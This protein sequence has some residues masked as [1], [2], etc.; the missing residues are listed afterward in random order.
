[1]PPGKQTQETSQ[2]NRS[3]QQLLERTILGDASQGEQDVQSVFMQALLGA[4]EGGAG[5]GNLGRGIQSQFRQLLQDQQGLPSQ[6][7]ISGFLQGG[8]TN[9]QRGIIDQQG[10][11]LTD[12]IIN[13]SRAQIEDLLR[14]QSSSN[15]AGA[16]LSG[17]GNNSVTAGREASARGRGAVAFSN[18]LNNAAGIRA[19]L[20]FQIGQGLSSDRQRNLSA[21]GSLANI[22]GSLFGAQGQAAGQQGQLALGELGQLRNLRLAGSTRAR[23]GTGSGSSTGTT[24]AQQGFGFGD[25]INPALAAFLLSS[26]GGGTNG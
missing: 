15:N 14:T 20:P 26:G 5:L 25:L 13:Q 3:F 10:R 4:G 8:V 17:F 1:M 23:T 21:L 16:A 7:D 6:A 12:P 24:T 18:V 19:Q 2:S 22:G 9:Q 11:A